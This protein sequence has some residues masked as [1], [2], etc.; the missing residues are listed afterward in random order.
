M[1]A[2]QFEGQL[3]RLLCSVPGF[4]RSEP[5]SELRGSAKL[6]GRGLSTEVGA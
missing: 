3:G 1:N 4:D 6:D 5:Q 2:G